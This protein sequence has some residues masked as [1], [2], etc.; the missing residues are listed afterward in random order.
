MDSDGPVTKVFIWE[1]LRDATAEMRRSFYSQEEG[2]RMKVRISRLSE[3]MD[4]LRIELRGE[5]ESR[6]RIIEGID[7]VRFEG[8]VP[9]PEVKKKIDQQQLTDPN[10]P[11]SRF[12]RNIHGNKVLVRAGAETD[13]QLPVFEMSSVVGFVSFR[14]GDILFF[15]SERA[16]NI[17]SS[18]DCRAY[19]L[20][21]TISEFSL[22]DPHLSVHFSIRPGAGTA[23]T[24]NTRS[25]PFCLQVSMG[26]RPPTHA[27]R[28]LVQGSSPE[29]GRG[30][31]RIE[32]GERGDR[33]TTPP[34]S[35]GGGAYGQGRIEDQMRGTLERGRG[36]PSPPLPPSNHF[37]HAPPPIIDG[38]GR[39]IG[40]AGLHVGGNR[41]FM[42]THRG[43]ATRNI[44][45]ASREREREE[46]RSKGGDRGRGRVVTDGTEGTGGAWRMS[47]KDMER[48][49]Q[50]ESRP[51]REGQGQMG[52]NGPP[53][54]VRE[55][56]L[57]F[58]QPSLSHSLPYFY[59]PPFPQIPQQTWPHY[60]P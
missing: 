59:L 47:D 23:K 36:N 8:R 20:F 3:Q 28:S 24:L 56:L 17:F 34:F 39:G 22:D 18:D 44:N 10:S 38:V 54:G 50:R 52:S 11:P 21:S 48:M 30:D 49:Q 43:G 40:G 31:G 58:P 16:A 32:T 27:Q 46:G 4:R 19:P 13:G 33:R 6:V 57:A 29:K 15:S 7:F 2:E 9:P 55:P 1:A 14:G 53:T 26:Q 37:G 42:L 51:N 5:G 35:Q 25:P 41:D 60:R 45:S 12:F